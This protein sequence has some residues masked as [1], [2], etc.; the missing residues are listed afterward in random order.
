MKKLILDII[1][2]KKTSHNIVPSPHYCAG[3]TSWTLGGV[4]TCSVVRSSYPL[5]CESLLCEANLTLLSI[6]DRVLLSLL[7]AV[8]VSN[9]FRN[10]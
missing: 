10:G 3:S 7:S 9:P 6:I 4:Q 2:P 8:L 1:T 5:F